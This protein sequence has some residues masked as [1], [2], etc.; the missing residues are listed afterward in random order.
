MKLLKP[1]GL[2]KNVADTEPALLLPEKRIPQKYG[3]PESPRIFPQAEGS[4][5]ERAGIRSI[6]AS[7]FFD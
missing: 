6:C 5:V 1:A 4:C 7:P 3:H 2:L